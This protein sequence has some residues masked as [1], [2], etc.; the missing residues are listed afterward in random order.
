MPGAGP[1]ERLSRGR[2]W[3]AWELERAASLPG[4]PPQATR[5]QVSRRVKGGRLVHRRGLSL[6]WPSR[7][8]GGT[9]VLE[10]GRRCAVALGMRPR[11]SLETVSVWRG[12]SCGCW[13]DWV[14]RRLGRGNSFAAL[15]R[16]LPPI[17]LGVDWRGISAAWPCHWL[18][19]VRD[20][21]SVL[22][23]QHRRA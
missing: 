16:W 15:L 13:W 8:K 6:T 4:T 7:G 12:P 21:G 22:R 10:V 23:L 1:A 11:A 17:L 20:R 14:V 19:P 3:E 18:R 9:D 5:P 2:G